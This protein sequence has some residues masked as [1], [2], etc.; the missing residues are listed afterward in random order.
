MPISAASTNG[1]S[2]KTRYVT[3]AL[4]SPIRTASVRFPDDASDVMSRR[5]LI[6][7]RAHE[8]S[9]AGTDAA[10][11]SHDRRPLSTYAVPAPAATPKN[12]KPDPSPSPRYPYGRGP[13]V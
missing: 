8:S 9:P 7:S 12:T 3:R 2:R 5:L 10:S 13:P 11:P 1:A 4:A 6:I